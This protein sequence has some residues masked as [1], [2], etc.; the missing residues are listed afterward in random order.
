[1]VNGLH[2]ENV[3]QP[4]MSSDPLSREQLVRYDGSVV[5]NGEKRQSLSAILLEIEFLVQSLLGNQ[6]IVG[7]LLYDLPAVDH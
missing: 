2:K 7:S 4:S 3:Y 1:M 6:F 5:F